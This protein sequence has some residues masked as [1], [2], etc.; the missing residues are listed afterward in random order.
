MEYLLTMIMFR[1]AVHNNKLTSYELGIL[2]IELLFSIYVKLL[3]II[4]IIRLR[5]PNKNIF[6]EAVTQLDAESLKPFQHT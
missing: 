2:D 6:M 3:T 1:Q 5:L 4:I